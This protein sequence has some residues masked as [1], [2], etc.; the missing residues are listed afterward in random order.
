MFCTASLACLISSRFGRLC[1]LRL[2]GDWGVALNE[3]L[4]GQEQCSV[5]LGG[6]AL[7]KILQRQKRAGNEAKSFIF[8]LLEDTVLVAE[9]RASFPQESC[10]KRNKGKGK[11]LCY[12]QTKPRG[13]GS[14]SSLREVDLPE[15]RYTGA[16]ASPSPS[17]YHHLPQPTRFWARRRCVR[18]HPEDGLAP[19]LGKPTSGFT[20]S[21][22]ARLLHGRWSGCWPAPLR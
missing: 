15:K 10:S 22:P 14:R 8:V 18:W 20:C 16:V 13:T 5:C 9:M 2:A 21:L 4:N 6:E 3:G 1:S 12:E 19:S 7:K 11:G 17:R